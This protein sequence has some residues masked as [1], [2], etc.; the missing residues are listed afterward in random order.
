M[1]SET[2]RRH[3]HEVIDWAADYLRDV[4]QYSVL[5]SVSPGD[6]R[7]QLPDKPPVDGEGMDAILHDF[8]EI[9][10]P[11]V[12]HRNHPRFFAYF[13]ANHSGPSILGRFCNQR[14]IFG[15]L[16]PLLDQSKINNF[17]QSIVC[18][19]YHRRTL[20]SR[21]LQHTHNR[22]LNVCLI[23]RR[24]RKSTRAVMD[25]RLRQIYACLA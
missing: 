7:K 1:D 13:P 15:N 17:R 25:H 18:G 20:L 14:D 22:I 2:F 11:G 8:R 24:Q 19:E 10:L 6:I 9:I 3:G 23:F 5:P 21:K 12:T 4:E 16:Q